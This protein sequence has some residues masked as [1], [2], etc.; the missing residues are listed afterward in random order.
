VRALVLVCL[1][2]CLGRHFRYIDLPLPPDQAKAEIKADA[3]DAELAVVDGKTPCEGALFCDDNNLQL[4]RGTERTEFLLAPRGAG[5]RLEIVQWG[6][7]P[8][9]LTPGLSRRPVTELHPRGEAGWADRF[10]FDYEVSAQVERDPRIGLGW[11]TNFIG[12]AGV[13]VLRW[14]ELGDAAR[15]GYS[16]SILAGPGIAIASTGPSLLPELTLEFDRQSLVS[17]MPGEHLPM[18]PRDAI[19]LSIAGR[20][21]DDEQ[22]APG[23]LTH[24]N[25]IEGALTVRRV[26]LGGV[27]MR[28]GFL[29]GP[30]GGKT[31]A[32]GVR[33]I[34][35][36][37]ALWATIAVAGIAVVVLAVTH[38]DPIEPSKG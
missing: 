21:L 20:F 31:Y 19:D 34:D 36:W 27:T 29:F 8:L 7:G 6:E 3:A 11:R 25:G 2:G 16:M 5:S 4:W 17:P 28:A 10:V 26:G 24:R 13:R 22:G 32:I 30:G 33:A 38:P 18:G 23:S 12:Q 15:T 37:H 1:V 35:P 9:V 14:G